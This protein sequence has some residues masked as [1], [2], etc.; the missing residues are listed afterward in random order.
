MKFLLAFIAAACLP[1]AGTPTSPPAPG[2]AAT[3][4]PSGNLVELYFEKP[5]RVVAWHAGTATTIAEETPFLSDAD[6]TSATLGWKR[7]RGYVVY[8]ELS[9]EGLERLREASLGNLGRTAIFTLEGLGRASFH[10]PL[11]PASDA[12]SFWGDLSEEEAVGIVERI[13]YRPIPTPLP[14][15]SPTPFG[16]QETV[17]F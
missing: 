2:A 13:N 6:F 16:G 9:P 7:G 5:A 1:A 10:L 15:S 3:P 17:T 11:E 14:A 8:C 4:K 12:L